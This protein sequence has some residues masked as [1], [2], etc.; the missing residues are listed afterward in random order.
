MEFYHYKQET[1]VDIYPKHGLIQGGTPISVMGYDYRYW[2]EWG[3]VPHCKF[4]DK[5]VKGNFDSSVRIV[6][7]SPPGLAVGVDLPFS[8]SLNG[9][10]WTESTISYSYYKQP[11]I[12]SYSPDSGQ[13]TGGTEVFFKGKN[14]PNLTDI[15]ECNAR[16]KPRSDDSM[17]AKIVPVEWLNDTMLKIT[18]PG[19]WSKGDKMDLQLTWNGIDYDTNN[20]TFTVYQIT[21]V[22]PR[23]GPSDGTGGDVI[24]KGYGF[25]PEK[26]AL[27]RLNGKIVKRSS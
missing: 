15:R 2:P 20:N 26:E 21:N 9:H 18:V 4:G 6:C 23:S 19:G 25:R 12:F 11:Q 3:V 14:F 22:K 10:D 7:V 27:C 1:T 13:S 8:V 24:I 5:I 16:L 17:E